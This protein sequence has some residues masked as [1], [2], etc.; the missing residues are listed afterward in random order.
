MT[1]CQLA[2]RLVEPGSNDQEAAAVTNCCRGHQL[3]PRSPTAAAVT[4]CCRDKICLACHAPHMRP[5]PRHLPWRA[6]CTRHGAPASARSSS[7]TVDTRTPFEHTLLPTTLK[8][9]KKQTRVIT[10]DDA[11]VFW[12]SMTTGECLILREPVAPLLEFSLL[13][14]NTTSGE[15]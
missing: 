3:L 8:K 1:W 5:V 6:P 11:Q 10:I 15:S 2:Q 14:L 13:Q 12:R 4:N 7:G 9:L